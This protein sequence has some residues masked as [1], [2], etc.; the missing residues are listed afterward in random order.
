MNELAI[1]TDGSLN[2]QMKVGVG[3]IM[4][5]DNDIL[6]K[7]VQEIN[8]RY[9][10]DLMNFVYF[11]NTSS[12]KLEIETLLKAIDDIIHN[13]K[14]ENQKINIYTD[15]QGITGLMNRKERLLNNDFIASSSGKEL[16]NKELYLKFYELNDKYSINIHKVK[17]H[18]QKGT[19]DTMTRIFSFLDKEVRRKLREFVETNKNTFT[20]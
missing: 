15:S 19:Q 10:I 1:F 2:P 12:T 16:K 11:Q 8:S 20:K 13:D 18:S 7:S 6:Q 5:F 9:F 14:Y 4:I 17:G 3:G